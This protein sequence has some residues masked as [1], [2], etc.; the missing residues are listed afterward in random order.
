MHL[1]YSYYS[2]SSLHTYTLT[3]TCWTVHVHG[4]SLLLATLACRL[5]KLLV[6]NCHHARSSLVPFSSCSSLAH[7]DG[8]C[9][10]CS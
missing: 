4:F 5:L 8:L 2:S 9:A 3:L 10:M 6:S 1:I 7:M